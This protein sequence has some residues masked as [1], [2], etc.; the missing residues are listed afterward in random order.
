MGKRRRL[1][2]RGM[3]RV[4]ADIADERTVAPDPVV[5]G[6]IE[7][8]IIGEGRGATN[9]GIEHDPAATRV[10]VGVRQDTDEASATA[11]ITEVVRA[12][13]TESRIAAMRG[14]RTEA[15]DVEAGAEAEVLAVV[16]GET[17]YLGNLDTGP[18]VG[19]VAMTEENQGEA[20]I[21]RAVGEGGL[22]LPPPLHG[23]AQDHGHDH[24]QLHHI[25]HCPKR[26]QYLNL[27][28]HCFLQALWIKW[29]VE[30]LRSL[31]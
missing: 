29:M 15:L 28:S 24:D 26:L 27:P 12:V 13:G 10:E 6:E 7:I 14:G 16:V 30:K 5:A 31:Q 2:V 22:D 25:H 17:E 11:A 9:Q 19:P 18:P 4:V 21:R 1:L 3:L 20:L 23:R 8:E